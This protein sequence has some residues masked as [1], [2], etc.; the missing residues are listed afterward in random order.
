MRFKDKTDGGRHDWWPLFKYPSALFGP[1]LIGLIWISVTFFLRNEHYSD[2][3]AA[4]QSAAN[5]AEAFEEHLARSIGEIDRDLK[6]I[7]AR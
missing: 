5:L 1:I 3:R 4:V 2:E 6:I 7:R